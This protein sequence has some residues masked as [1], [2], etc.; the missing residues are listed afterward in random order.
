MQSLNP[1][2]KIL[3][4]QIRQ[5]MCVGINVTLARVRVTVVAVEKQQ[6]LHIL[7]VC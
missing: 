5:A 4:Q 3:G 6:V 1:S 7:N 2:A